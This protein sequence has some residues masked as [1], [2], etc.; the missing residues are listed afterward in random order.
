VN[1]HQL[2][3]GHAQVLA[4]GRAASL[5][6]PQLGLRQQ[7]QVG[8]VGERPAAAGEPLGIE[9]RRRRQA[10]QLV[11]KQVGDAGWHAPQA[12]IT[13]ARVPERAELERR[14][15]DLLQRL[16]RFDTVNPPGNEAPLQEFL[17][18]LLTAAGF[19]C[20][21][22]AAV[23]GRPNL[24]ARMKAASDGPALCLLGHVDTVL[25]DPEGWTID[26]WAGEL[27]DGCIWGRGAIDMKSQVAA[28]TAAAIALAEEGWRPQ[29][30]ELLLVFTCDEETGAVAGAQWLCREHPDRVRADFVVNEGAGQVI[31]HEGRRV[32]GVCLG[33][34]GV[35]RFKLTSEGRAG[36]ASVPRVGD[37]A[38]ARLGPVLTALQERRP[39]LAPPEESLRLLEALGLDAA[40]PEAALTELARLDAP[41]SVLIE[42]LLGVSFAPTILRAGDKINVIPAHAELEVDCRVPPELGE[43]EVHEALRGVLGEHGFDIEF[44]HPVAGNRSPADTPLMESIRAFVA[45]EDP[46]A[47]VAPIVMWGFSDSNWWRAAFPQSVVY[48]FFPQGAMDFV[49]GFPLVHGADE[50]IPVEDLGMAAAFYSELMQETLR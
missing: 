13:V 27:R 42:P 35:F 39:P 20:E 19:D 46:G 48:G 11:T 40:H 24:I 22:L 38:L 44:S 2:L 10:V 9:R 41:L 37:N 6:V 7:R 14:T 4:Q 29:A 43:A 34:K 26:P 5:A 45:R 1:P 31:R 12:A 23:E 33:E 36:H 28:E 50:R 21:L 18:E 8:K 15:A 25:A 47:T 49:E 17:R 3:R 32:Y 30:G 16:I